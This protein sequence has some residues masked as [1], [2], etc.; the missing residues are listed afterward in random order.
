MF[1]GIITERIKLKKIQKKSNLL[2]MEF[3][4]PVS[5]KR[6][7][8]VGESL[9]LGGI[10]STV[11]RITK[12]AFEVVYMDET[13]KK[14]NV[15]NWKSG[16]SINFEP[17]LKV[18]D[19]LSGH[20]V[21]GHIDT[22]GTVKSITTIGGSKVFE[23]SLPKE[24]LKYIVYKGSIALDGVSLTVSKKGSKSFCVSIIPFTLSHT[25]FGSIDV[26]Y[27]INIETDVL[28][29]YILQNN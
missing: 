28:G 1:T 10:C 16:D 17:S 19:T 11:V 24:F 5:M 2:Y 23:I 13:Q 21:Y 18:G 14:T 22:V 7:L 6:R 26:G 27:T 4:L 12:S 20:F 9:S 3:G 25:G 29:K 15:L 8:V